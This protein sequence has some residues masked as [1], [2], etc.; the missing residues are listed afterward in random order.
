L[1]KRVAIGIII[2]AIAGTLI[3]LI[4]TAPTFPQ[5]IVVGVAC[6]L[7]LAILWPSLQSL[8]IRLQLEEWRLE[9]VE[10]QG[11]KFISAGYQRRVAWRLFVEMATRISTQPLDDL[12]GDDGIALKSLYDLFRLTR[13]TI[14]EMEPTRSASGNTV[15]TYALDMLNADLRPFLSKWHPQWE[16]HVSAAGEKHSQEWELHKQFRSELSELQTKI[17]VRARGL[18]TIAGLKN[19]DRFFPISSVTDT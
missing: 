11:L 16:T 8:L 3:F 17:E 19:V 10:I 13:T 15:E 1:I 6:G 5:S 12:V 18:A 9:Q 7:V 14:S 2:G 4:A